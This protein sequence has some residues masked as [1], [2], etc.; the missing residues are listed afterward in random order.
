MSMAACTFSNP[1]HLAAF[2]GAGKDA[3]P[4]SV[5]TYRL[6]SP[7]LVQ[8]HS[9]P[10]HG[11]RSKH[12]SPDSQKTQ[13]TDDRDRRAVER[14]W[15]LQTAWNGHEVDRDDGMEDDENYSDEDDIPSLPSLSSSRTSS[16]SDDEHDAYTSS[17]DFSFDHSL[18]SELFQS[19][20]MLFDSSPPLPSTSPTKRFALA[21]PAGRRRSAKRPLHSSPPPRAP[22]RANRL[23]DLVVSSL[24]RSQPL[25]PTLQLVSAFDPDLPVASPIP[26]STRR[27]SVSYLELSDELDLDHH[28]HGEVLEAPWEWDAD[29]P[30]EC[31]GSPNPR[32][33]C[34]E[35]SPPPPPPTPVSKSPRPR[36][37]ANTAQLLMLSLE[38][39]MVRTGK[40]VSPLRQ[41][42][43]VVRHG[44][45][46][47]PSALRTEVV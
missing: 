40:I 12:L 21:P 27:P 2:D 19:P 24:R 7:P 26:A 18:P 11:W 38:A 29:A 37:V 13:L 28:E 14:G 32:S 16:S 15:T 42:G 43:V 34:L 41:R 30:T 17:E 45:A 25:L 3:V 22:A 39:T 33:A 10:R 5:S 36:L 6:L 9:T 23:P 46:E 20:S 4:A 44:R 1:H 35:L 8:L 47:Q 31:P